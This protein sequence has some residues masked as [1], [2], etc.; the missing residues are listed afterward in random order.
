MQHYRQQSRPEGVDFA[1][2]PRRLVEQWAPPDVAR[3]WVPYPVIRR[4]DIGWAGY[5]A[6]VWR[7][8]WCP[9]ELARIDPAKVIGVF[10]RL[11]KQIDAEY[12]S[13][14]PSGPAGVVQP[15]ADGFGLV[16]RE[17]VQHDVDVE[18]GGDVEV[19]PLE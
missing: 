6:R 18:V 3:Y 1:R 10:T 8:T 4:D 19:D 14:M 5:L 13:Q 2:R 17:V 12:E 11:G 15:L 7:A 16:G 9:F